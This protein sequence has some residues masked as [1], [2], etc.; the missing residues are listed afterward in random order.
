MST[1]PFPEAAI[2]PTF[3]TILG[4][5]LA[6]TIILAVYALSL[7]KKLRKSEPEEPEYNTSRLNIS[8]ST[9][10]I[11]EEV[12][13]EPQLQ[14]DLPGLTNLSKATVSESIKTLKQENLIKR[15]KRGNT[16]LIEPWTEKLE[17]QC[18]K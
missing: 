7:R 17:E 13:N 12:I 16:Y 11:L 4:I 18:G 10:K 5:L 15:K 2:G 6:T 8:G 14:S 9:R 3:F 1:L